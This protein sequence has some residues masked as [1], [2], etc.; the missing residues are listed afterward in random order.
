MLRRDVKRTKLNL[1][2]L[3]TRKL[4]AADL[5]GDIL[6]IDGT[7]AG[8]EIEVRFDETG[9]DEVHVDINGDDDEFDL[10]DVNEIRVR[11]LGGNDTIHILNDADDPIPANE[12]LN[13]INSLRIEGGADN[14]TIINDTVLAMTAFGND[15]T[16]IIRGGSGNDVIQGGGQT[17][18]LYGRGGNDK[19]YGFS[20]NLSASNAD[21]VRDYLY[22]GEGRDTLRG[23]GGSD[24][25]YGGDFANA[26]DDIN[27]MYGDDGN[28]FLYGGANRDYMYG[29]NGTDRL[30]GYDGNDRLYGEAGQDYLYGGDDNDFLNGGLD[31]QNDVLRG[32]QGQDEFVQYVWC[33]VLTSVYYNTENDSFV[34]FGSGDTVRQQLGMIATIGYLVI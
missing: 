30:R 10:D 7:A 1:E 17:D 21:D 3:E 13:Y 6:Y 33:N 15:G 22:G 19:L 4:M 5:V 23:G 29:G 18:Y 27:Y 31:G 34:D 11:G 16:D 14:D 12:L 32:D 25:L 2:S 28:D 8:D 24:F 26:A 9:V 20:D